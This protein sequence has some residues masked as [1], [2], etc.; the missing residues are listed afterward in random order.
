MRE[1]AEREAAA[2][3]ERARRERGTPAGPAPEGGRTAAGH[4]PPTTREELLAELER[5]EEQ[6]D[7]Q[8]A[9]EDALAHE[10][11]AAELERATELLERWV[12]DPSW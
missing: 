6:L 3:L 2:R 11:D 4:V 7:T 1:R 5:I 12:A 10:L 9:E 8:R